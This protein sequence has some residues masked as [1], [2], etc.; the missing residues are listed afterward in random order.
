MSFSHL[1]LLVLAEALKL[2]DSEN[3]DNPVLHQ[4]FLVLETKIDEAIESAE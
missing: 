1:E 2:Y 3:G 4:L